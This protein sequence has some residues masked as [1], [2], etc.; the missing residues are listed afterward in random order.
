MSEIDGSEQHALVAWER[1]TDD[2]VRDGVTEELIARSGELAS[3]YGEEA[4]VFA[5]VASAF[6]LLGHIDTH[7]S[8]GKF[9]SE[10]PPFDFSFAEGR[11]VDDVILT[12]LLWQAI[13]EGAVTGSGDEDTIY[14]VGD[15]VEDMRGVGRGDLDFAADQVWRW[16]IDIGADD[17]IGINFCPSSDSFERQTFADQGRGLLRT[18]VYLTQRGDRHE[19][20]LLLRSCAA[21]PLSIRMMAV[22]V[23]LLAE[24]PTTP[25]ELGAAQRTAYG[26]FP[27]CDDH[28]TVEPVLTHVVAGIDRFLASGATADDVLGRLAELDAMSSAVHPP[29]SAEQA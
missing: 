21:A 17:G 20:E 7:V 15:V 24:P 22:H 10:A 9:L 12:A 5:K 4:G 13:V 8:T 26:R 2:A 25:L 29:D 19:A 28:I 18:A 16:A 27:F 3:L 11:S 23:D 6:I 14:F 1:L